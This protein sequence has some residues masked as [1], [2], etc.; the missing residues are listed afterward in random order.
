MAHRRIDV[1]HHIV[2]PAYAAWLRAAGVSDAG[3]RELPEWSVEGALGLMDEQEIATA[4]VSATAPGVHLDPSKGRDP[5]ARAKARELNEVAGRMAQDHPDRFGFFA[6]LTLPDVDGALEEL[7]HA[8]DVL[9]ASGVI[10]LANTHG[11]YLGAAHEPLLAELDR[12][13]AVVFVHPAVLPGPAVEGIPPFAADFLLDTTPAAYQLVRGGA[14]RRY[15]ALKIILSH[16]GGFVPYASHR[17]AMAI[18][19]DTQRAPLEILD[20]FGLLFRHRA[21]RHACGAAEP[22]RIREAGSRALRQR[23]AV[24]AGAGRGLLHPPARRVRRAR[25]GGPRVGR[26]ARG[27]GAVPALRRGM[28]SDASAAWHRARSG[29]FIRAARARR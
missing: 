9:G 24:R 25:C 14:I 28:S 17:L 23:L 13:R 11:R 22:A 12:R 20:D 26:S 29:H 6:M 5:V 3:G 4:I 10:L 7:T 15:A 19:A 8:F 18:S 1:H 16:A 27:G 21:V 2:P